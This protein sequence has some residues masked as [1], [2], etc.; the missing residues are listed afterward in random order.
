MSEAEK[1]MYLKKLSKTASFRNN[2]LAYLEESLRKHSFE[3]KEHAQ[4]LKI[5]SWKLG[6]ALGLSPGHL[7]ELSLVAALHDI[8]NLGGSDK[9]T[10]FKCYH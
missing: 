6:Q 9:F 4:R 8:G 10:S 5:L 1:E 7:R 2:V 3:T